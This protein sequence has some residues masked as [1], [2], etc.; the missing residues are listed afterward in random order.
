[1][2]ILSHIYKRNKRAYRLCIQKDL[3]YIFRMRLCYISKFNWSFLSSGGFV[4]RSRVQNFNYLLDIDLS[5]S[6]SPMYFH[7]VLNCTY[8]IAGR[9]SGRVTA[10]QTYLTTP[11]THN[12]AILLSPLIPLRAGRIRSQDHDTIVY[13]P[14]NRV[15]LA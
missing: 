10:R 14:I 13:G 5:W 1:M 11:H 12:N 8:D 9:R 4:Y 7:V 2:L 6:L 3:F 15:R